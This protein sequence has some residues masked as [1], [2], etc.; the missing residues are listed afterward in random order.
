[1]SYE[2]EACEPLIAEAEHYDAS[3]P[4]AAR[5]VVALV[6][7]EYRHYILAAARRFGVPTYDV[8]DVAQEVFITINK[9]LGKFEGRAKLSTWIRAIVFRKASE[10]RRKAYR[11]RELPCAEFD[12][13]SSFDDPVELI[14]LDQQARTLWAAMERL[15]EEQRCVLVLYHLEQ[16]PVAMIA[17]EMGCPQYTAYTRLR[18]ARQRMRVYLDAQAKPK[19]IAHAESSES[20]AAA[21][22][23]GRPTLATASVLISR[24]SAANA[25]ASSSRSTTGSTT[26]ST[27]E[28]PAGESRSSPRGI[29]TR[30][31]RE[32]S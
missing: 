31:N 29:S 8:E 5:P 21:A 20:E 11:T 28:A 30:P 3:P 14:H 26:G 13:S 19:R 27:T 25:A 7:Q 16:R 10:H 4:T 22:S 12:E 32:P 6:I 17:A 15:P 1:M 9:E 23:P 18:T 2:S 24:R